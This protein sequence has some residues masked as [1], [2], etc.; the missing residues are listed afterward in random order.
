[1]EKIEAGRAGAKKPA[2]DLIQEERRSSEN[3]A[4][5]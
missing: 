4:R 3:D 5:Q 2:P 1:L